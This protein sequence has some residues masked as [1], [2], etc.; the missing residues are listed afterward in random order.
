M[1]NNG[2]R[3]IANPFLLKK[4]MKQKKNTK[5]VEIDTD[6]LL[7]TY[8]DKKYQDVYIHHHLFYQIKE[9]INQSVTEH[10]IRS[11]LHEIVDFVSNKFDR[12]Q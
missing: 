1:D 9:E 8:L 4:E 12:A 2:L 7:F 11:V 5:L 6:Q 10:I 3:I